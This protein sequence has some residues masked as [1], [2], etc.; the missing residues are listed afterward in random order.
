M[1]IIIQLYPKLNHR[2]QT[3]SKPT[4]KG[5]QIHSVGVV[6]TTDVLVHTIDKAMFKWKYVHC[7]TYTTND[8]GPIS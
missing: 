4:C 5:R 7:Y 8:D 1:K 3:H 2:I 6:D